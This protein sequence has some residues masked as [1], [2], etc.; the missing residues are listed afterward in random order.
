M[1]NSKTATPVGGVL[2]AAGDIALNA[3]RKST[4]IKVRNTGDRPI[5]VGSHYHFFEA[6]RYLEFNRVEAFGKHLDIPATTAIRFEPGDEK[7]VPLVPFGG[8]CRMVGF[9]GLVSGY[10]GTEDAPNYLPVQQR[11]F[12]RVRKLGFKCTATTCDCNPTCECEPT[13]NCESPCACAINNP[14]NQPHE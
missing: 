12:R 5:Q 6:N 3:T 8:K 10:A 9:N 13:C 2:L 4:T 7:E 11:A 1:E 14:K